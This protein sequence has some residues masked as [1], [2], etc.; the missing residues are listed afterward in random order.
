ML[1]PDQT[2]LFLQSMAFISN[3]V[4][5]EWSPEASTQVTEEVLDLYFSSPKKGGGPYTQ[6]L[7]A[8]ENNSAV[9]VFEQETGE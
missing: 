7:M 6:I 8:P 5:V 3:K 4:L 2:C 9:I 1:L